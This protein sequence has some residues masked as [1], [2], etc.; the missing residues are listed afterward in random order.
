MKIHGQQKTLNFSNKNGFLDSLTIHSSE[1]TIVV[2]YTID[3]SAYK[4]PSDILLRSGIVKNLVDPGVKGSKF[5]FST[6]QQKEFWVFE[7]IHGN[8]MIR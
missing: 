6:D 3:F 8:Y 2:D 1:D 5:I 7:F 4:I